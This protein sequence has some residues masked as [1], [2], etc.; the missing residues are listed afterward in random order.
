MQAIFSFLLPFLPGFSG[1]GK[2]VSVKVKCAYNVV[3]NFLWQRSTFTSCCSTEQDSLK[4]RLSLAVVLLGA[5]NIILFLIRNVLQTNSD[6]CKFNTYGCT[7]SAEGEQLLFSSLKIN[8]L[9]W[10]FIHF[11]LLRK[12]KSSWDFFF[13]T[14]GWQIFL[15]GRMATCKSLGEYHWG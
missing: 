15:D 10:L 11:W 13:L 3:K 14:S 4:L 6:T 2:W 1:R 8:H 7:V 12:P 9:F 5:G